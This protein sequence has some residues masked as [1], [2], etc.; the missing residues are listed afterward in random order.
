MTVHDNQEE[1]NLHVKKKETV[2]GSLVKIVV[3]RKNLETGSSTVVVTT[4]NR[5]VV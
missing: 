1:S 5:D 3:G 2:S 4:R